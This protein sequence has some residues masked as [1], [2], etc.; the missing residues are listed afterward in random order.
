MGT[1]VDD[2]VITGH[3]EAY[4]NSLAVLKEKLGLSFKEGTFR[5]CGKLVENTDEGIYISQH[6]A[7]G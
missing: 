2:E 7:V 1:H 6:E 5:Y 4:E 3:G